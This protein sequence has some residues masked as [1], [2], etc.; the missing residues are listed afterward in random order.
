MKCRCEKEFCYLC[1]GN[2]PDCLCRNRPVHA[3]AHIPQIPRGRAQRQ[4]G[5]LPRRG[6]VQA[7]RAAPQAPFVPLRA[8]LTMYNIQQSL[9]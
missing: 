7:V 1:G 3:Q 8:A 5:R 6:R 2:Y 9:G 4:A